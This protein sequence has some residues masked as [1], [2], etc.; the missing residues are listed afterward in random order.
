MGCRH[1]C[2]TRVL[3]L[4]WHLG[5]RVQ[6]TGQQLEAPLLPRERVRA[7]WSPRASLTSISILGR[8]PLFRRLTV[9]VMFYALVEVPALPLGRERTWWAHT[10]GGHASRLQTAHMT[11]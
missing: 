10:G 3:R 8:T 1:V 5:E 6:A 2:H 11:L 7:P 4:G 9:L